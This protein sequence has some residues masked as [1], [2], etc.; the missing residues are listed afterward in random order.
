MVDKT[1]PTLTCRKCGNVSN[2]SW[3]WQY[4]K[5]CGNSLQKPNDIT[6]A[7]FLKYGLLG[8]FVMKYLGINHPVLITLINI[9]VALMFLALIFFLIMFIGFSLG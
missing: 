6:Q 3:E 9:F 5:K 4:C 1:F 8:I 7:K 2:D